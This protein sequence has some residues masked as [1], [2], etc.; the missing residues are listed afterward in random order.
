VPTDTLPDALR[1]FA[2]HQPLTPVI[3]T[4][5]DLWTGAEIGGQAVSAVAWCLAITAVSCTACA[6]LFRRRVAT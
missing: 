1:G 5:R 4:L 2:E 3:E 6:A